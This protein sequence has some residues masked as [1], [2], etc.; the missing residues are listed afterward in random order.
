MALHSTAV[1]D[2]ALT[3]F[4]S[5]G[6]GEPGSPSRP[7]AAGRGVTAGAVPPGGAAH[8]D[9]FADRSRD[10]PSPLPDHPGAPAARAAPD[11]TRRAHAVPAGFHQR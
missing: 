1:A 7:Q 8:H 6:A 10:G 9:G 4:R 2:R 3:P 5:P 11:G